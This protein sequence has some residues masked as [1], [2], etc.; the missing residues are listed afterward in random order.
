MLISVSLRYV[1]DNMGVAVDDNGRI[2]IRANGTY[3]WSM[4]IVSVLTQILQ[5]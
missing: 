2:E 1:I 5:A 3:A 4:S